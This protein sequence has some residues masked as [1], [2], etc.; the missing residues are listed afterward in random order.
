MRGFPE[1]CLKVYENCAD[2]LSSN[3]R[4]NEISILTFF[5]FYSKKKNRNQSEIVSEATY[6]LHP[7]YYFE[8]LNLKFVGRSLM[9]RRFGLHSNS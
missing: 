3:L 7:N 5:Q 4:L 9:I 1:D 6:D 8:I 2:H